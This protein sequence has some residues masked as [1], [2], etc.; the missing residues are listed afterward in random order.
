MK[1]I[2]IFLLCCILAAACTEKTIMDSS[3]IISIDAGTTDGVCRFTETGGTVSL[4]VNSVIQEWEWE[5]VFDEGADEWCVVSE[6]ND[7]RLTIT[8]ESNYEGFSER[9][10]TLVAYCFD[11]GVEFRAECRLM[12]SSRT[13][14]IGIVLEDGSIVGNTEVAVPGSGSEYTFEVRSNFYPIEIL[15]E[16]D[17]IDCSIEL[18]EGDME[19]NSEL[20][21]EYHYTVSAIVHNSKQVSGRSATIAVGN[22]LTV[23]NEEVTV[24]ATVRFAQ[25]VFYGI[26]YTTTDGQ[27]ITISENGMD[28]ISHVYDDRYGYIELGGTLAEIPNGKFNGCTTLKTIELP[29]SVTRIGNSAFAA[30]TS[31]ESIALPDNLST[32][33]TSVFYDCIALKSIELPSGILTLPDNAFYGCAALESIGLPE[34]LSTLGTSVFYDCIA[35]KSVELPSGILTLPD[36]AFYGCVALESIGLPESLSAMGTHAFCNCTSLKSIEIPTSIT[37]LPDAAFRNCSSLESVILPDN[38]T[39]IGASTFRECSSLKSIELPQSV[40][41][42]GNCAF[43]DCSSLKSIFLPE[44]IRSVPYEAFYGCPDLVSV[45]LPDNLKSIGDWAFYHCLDLRE[46]SLPK[47]LER[48]GSYAFGSCQQLVN[49][50]IPEGVK[51][52]EEQTFSSC[53]N[54]QNVTIPETVTEIASGAFMYCGSIKS[55]TLPESIVR[56]GLAAFH[57]Y[58]LEKVIC[59]AT[60]PPSIIF[61]SHGWP[62]FGTDN[63]QPITIYV[64][65]ES[66]E[67]YRAADEW[68]NY[69]NYTI[70]PL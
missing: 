5:L 39:E 65:A 49:I 9:S 4:T 20:P 23:G 16:C 50:E 56:I 17:W 28:I 3:D 32:L 57:C 14:E 55:I 51:I 45:V 69:T 44:K 58:Q 36:N 8:A 27:K 52:I 63:E 60:E 41:T 30:C 26:R 11:N 1:K 59:L 13:P 24:S 62:T 18:I 68:K 37:S 33:G 43:R 66:V 21:V 22:V 34:S 29:Q 64:P 7:N 2:L 31:L 46:I 67:L 6:D 70:E 42:I 19:R 53:A 40:T 12:Q 61:S 25:G 47:T 15:S 48:I 35:L 38:L 54:L 10:A